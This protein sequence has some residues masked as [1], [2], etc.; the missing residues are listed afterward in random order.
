[1]MEKILV[2]GPGSLTGSRFVELGEKSFKL[3]G[4]GGAM[5]SNA[6]NLV[7]FWEMDI[8]SEKNVKVVINAYPGKYVIN[9]AGATLVDEIE[10]TKP[11]DP[12]DEKQ[13][14]QNIA[15]Q[16]NV[17]GTKFLAN[18]CKKSG[19]FPIFISTGF[20][21]DGKNGPYSEDDELASSPEDVSW[22]G[23]T[24]VLA[25]QEVVNSGVRCTTIRISYPY[26][27]EYPGKNDFARSMLK[28]YDDYKSGTRDSIYPYFS[29]QTLTPTFIDDIPE[30][31]NILLRKEV[32]GIFHLTSP[33]VTTP[34]EFCLELLK[35]AR[36]VEDTE[37]I[38]KKGSIEKFQLDNSDIAKRPVHGGEKSDKIIGLG[39]TPTS[40]KEGIEKVYGK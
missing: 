5:D 26:R 2:I 24:K 20:V 9:F 11:S 19:K 39:F 6:Q 14:N 4:A 25:E 35:V 22:Y 12:T 34:Y 16:V 38:I 32:D 33:E 1:M 37:G 30:V 28:V 21:F 18:A 8:T 3:Y 23:W 13:L 40:W 7:D 17:L 15:Y 29:D 31:V 36:N 27:S 10:K